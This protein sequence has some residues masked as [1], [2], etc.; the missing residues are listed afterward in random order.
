MQKLPFTQP[1]KGHEKGSFLEYSIE[2]TISDAIR[3]KL[4]T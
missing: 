4:A 3:F 2:T 1:D